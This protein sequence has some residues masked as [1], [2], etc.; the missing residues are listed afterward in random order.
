M[1]IILFFYF[2]LIIMNLIISSFTL[3]NNFLTSFNNKNIKHKFLLYN[4]LIKKINK[5]Y[6]QSSKI[7][8]F[9]HEENKENDLNILISLFK[10]YDKELQ[11]FLINLHNFELNNMSLFFLNEFCNS[12]FQLNDLE[13]FQNKRQSEILPTI[14]FNYKIKKNII[15]NGV[16]K[17]IV[18]YIYNS[19]YKFLYLTQ[20]F[21]KSKIIIYE[22]DSIDDTLKIL[23][24]FKN[25]Y[26]NIDIIVLSEK[27]IQG[28]LTQRISH[29]RNT[30]LNYIHDNK[31]NP[32]Y[33][34]TLDM[35]DILLDFK[36]DS[37]L[38]PFYEKINW[39]MFGG[40]SEIYYDM[41]ALR[42]LKEPDKDFWKDKKINNKII[43]PIEKILNS[44]F[45][46]SQDSQPIPIFSCFNGIGIYKYKHIINCYYDGNNTCEH[47]HF[48][49]NMITKNNAKLFIHPKL[50]VGPH[51]ILSKPMNFYK[52]DKLVKNYI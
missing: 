20:Y 39:S 17:N 23:N 4:D 36:C 42:T 46:I 34:I 26:K 37:I 1:Y 28:I 14:L 19:L 18:K 47:I 49:Q 43:M 50:I 10:K 15:I 21:Q 44:Y 16:C 52:I 45:K 29:A 30:I 32:N 12:Q 8:F 35:D 9:Y 22:N 38:Y 11:L 6:L 13:F 40:N 48:H 27:N 24:E 33:L 41:W 25:K 3:N 5:K 7:I 51:K 31:L 2:I